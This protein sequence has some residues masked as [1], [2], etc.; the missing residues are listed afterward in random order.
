MS[1][2]GVARIL[3]RERPRDPFLPITI[4][5]AAVASTTPA[6]TPAIIAVRSPRRPRAMIASNSES[7]TV[8]LGISARKLAACPVARAPAT[9]PPPIAPSSTPPTP[10]PIAPPNVYPEIPRRAGSLGG[11][12]NPATGA[13]PGS[14]PDASFVAGSAEGT[15][16]ADGPSFV[17]RPLSSGSPC[18]ATYC[19][20]HVLWQAH[21]PPPPLSRR[22]RGRQR[23][24]RNART[25]H[26]DRPAPELTQHNTPR[27]TKIPPQLCDR[28]QARPQAQ[29]HDCR[30]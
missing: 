22:H 24:V 4:K 23:G 25:D 6:P 12:E 16:P 15:D 8:R 20:G 21:S 28:P 13:G 1:I 14:R 27:I 17:A 9:R 18:P 10:R 19:S 7:S 5:N 30:G 26:R 3:A 2:P 11:G 29:A